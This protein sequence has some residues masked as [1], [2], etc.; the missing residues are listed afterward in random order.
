MSY[1][2]NKKS[3]LVNITD[4]ILTT[5]KSAGYVVI[6]IITKI[7]QLLMMNSKSMK[8]AKMIMMK[9]TKKFKKQQHWSIL[10]LNKRK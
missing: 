7:H 1:F 4:A 5:L 9:G 2:V 8:I 3:L 6:M 10:S